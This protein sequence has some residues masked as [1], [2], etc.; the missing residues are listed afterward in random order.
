MT[1]V[2]PFSLLT[3]R[4]VWAFDRGDLDV[5]AEVLREA[6]ADPELDRQLVSVNA[7]LYAEAG[8]PPVREHSRG[9]AERPAGEQ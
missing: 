9:V 5:L 2:P 7:A 8:L 1:L 3:I 6:E 4:Y